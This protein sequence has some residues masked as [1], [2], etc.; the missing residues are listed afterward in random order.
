LGMDA[1]RRRGPYIPATVREGADSPAFRSLRAGHRQRARFQP[2]VREIYPQLQMTYSRSALK[3][4]HFCCQ[5]ANNWRLS[6]N[7]E[8]GICPSGDI[9]QI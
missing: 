4:M 7:W 9:Q 5:E 3:P 6:N 1:R 8:S 2:A